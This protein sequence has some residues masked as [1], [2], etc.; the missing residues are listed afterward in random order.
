MAGAGLSVPLLSLPPRNQFVFVSES[1]G[2]HEV[3]S[4]VLGWG[5]LVDDFVICHLVFKVASEDAAPAGTA[6]E[7]ATTI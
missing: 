1:R 5:G 2:L 7:A 6:P 4:Q 3:D